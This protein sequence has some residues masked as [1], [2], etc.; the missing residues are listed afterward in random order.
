ML[1]NKLHN[2]LPF[3]FAD[4]WSNSARS[5][6]E[7]VYMNHSNF[8]DALG[9][10]SLRHQEPTPGSGNGSWYN[11]RRQDLFISIYRNDPKFSD[12]QVWANSAGPDHCLQFPLHHLDS[13]L[14]GRATL[15]N[16]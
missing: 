6:K 10:Y 4:G 9:V 5:V 16:F 3:R 1:K 12:R 2:I 14:Y 8:S 7:G 13:L 11:Y 15:F